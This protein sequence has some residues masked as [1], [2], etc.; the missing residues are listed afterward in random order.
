MTPETDEKGWE[1]DLSDQYPAR[2]AN[3]NEAI[4]P[5]TTFNEPFQRQGVENEEHE[6]FIIYFVFEIFQIL[7]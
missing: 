1:T 5:S 3:T 4:S 6:G 2:N 7:K